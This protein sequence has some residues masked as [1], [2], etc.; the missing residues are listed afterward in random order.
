MPKPDTVEGPVLIDDALKAFIESGVSVIVGTRDESLTPEIVR[1]WGPH[2]SVDMRSI[3]LCVPFATSIRTRTNLAGN[4]QIAAAFCFPSDYQTVQLK[5]SQAR[6]AEPSADDL[7]V[8]DRHREAFAR[9]NQTLGIPRSQVEALWNRE[10]VSS[11]R[12]VALHFVVRQIFNQTPG[13]AAGL[14]L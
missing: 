14:E 6:T 10:L 11:S 2:V 3:S 5:G 12:L 9:E 1:A 7:R 13:P 4:G 8:V